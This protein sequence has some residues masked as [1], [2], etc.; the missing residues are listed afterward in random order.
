MTM[1]YDGSLYWHLGKRV[2][3]TQQVSDNRE[4]ARAM[5]QLGFT[6]AW[7]AEHHV[8]RRLVGRYPQQRHDLP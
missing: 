2:P 6:T 7:S 4:Y 1:R 8:A 5:E 3:W